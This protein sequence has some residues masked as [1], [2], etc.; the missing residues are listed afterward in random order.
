MEE[1]LIMDMERNF[2]GHKAYEIQLVF[3]FVII[4]I[5]FIGLIKK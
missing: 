5:D 2:S 3:I 4:K 1:V